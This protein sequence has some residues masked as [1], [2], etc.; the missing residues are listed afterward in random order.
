MTQKTDGKKQKMSFSHT[1]RFKVIK[2]QA[3]GAADAESWALTVISKKKKT[4]IGTNL[5]QN[6]IEQQ[7]TKELKR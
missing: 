1:R 5:V 2:K 3:Q 6:G 7:N 4:Y